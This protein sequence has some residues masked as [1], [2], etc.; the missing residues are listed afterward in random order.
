MKASALNRTEPVSEKIMPTK[1]ELRAAILPRRQSLTAVQQQ[2]VAVAVAR[3][4]A[5]HPVLGTLAPVAG[6][7]THRGEVDVAQILGWVVGRGHAAALPR[8]G[9]DDDKLQFHRW[10]KG[11]AT[12]FDRWNI[13]VPLSSSEIVLPRVVL[14]PL[15]AFD[16]RGYRLGY[17]GGFY[18]RTIQALREAGD[19][20]LFIGV[21]Y[22]FQEVPEIPI[23]AGDMPLDG[24]VTELGVSFFSERWR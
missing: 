14:V 4:Y 13:Q 16:R 19:A 5:D 9:E 12:E 10:Q 1:Q 22:Q 2:Q 24:V 3:H 15:V 21:A 18:D 6:Y 17:G 7:S 11:D 8:Q 20:P 23:G